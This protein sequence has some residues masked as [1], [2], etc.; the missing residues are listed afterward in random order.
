MLR[1]CR[2]WNKKSNGGWICPNLPSATAH[3]DRF[4][5][6]EEEKKSWDDLLSSS[7]QP[8]KSSE[9]LRSSSD[10]SSI[11]VNLLD[12]DQAAILC[13]LRTSDV[14]GSSDEQRADL[15]PALEARLQKITSTLEPQVD[16]FADGIHKVTQYRLAAER[17]ADKILASSA[18]ALERR[19]REAREKAGTADVSLGDV[20]GSLGRVLNEER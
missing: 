18:E 2:S 6:L 1:S 4:S 17:V 15:V 14:A 8:S 7:L 20:L 13:A 10:P 3:A 5:R 16:L 19:D 11:D 12:P 9:P